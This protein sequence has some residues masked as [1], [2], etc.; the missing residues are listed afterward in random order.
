[1][2]KL[3]DNS[4]RVSDADIIK[5]NVSI[6]DILHSFT[7]RQLRYNRCRCPVC[8]DGRQDA[9]VVDTKRNRAHCFRCGFDGDVIDIVGALC[10]LSFNDSIKRITN[11]YGL[12]DASEDVLTAAKAARALR[13]EEQ[14]RQDEALRR[15]HAALDRF[16]CL[17][18]WSRLPPCDPRYPI[19]VRELAKARYYLDLAEDEL[20]YL[21]RSCS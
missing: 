8:N 5:Q 15:Y 9:F 6:T 3:W 20:Y 13:T 10:G 17:D 11:D 12:S 21:Q 16:A 7:D 18:N 1:M 19:S 14:R 4:I 2:R